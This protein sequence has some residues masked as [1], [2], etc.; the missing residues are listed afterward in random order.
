MKYLTT[1][2]AGMIVGIGISISI[3]YV[4]GVAMNGKVLENPCNILA[5]ELKDLNCIK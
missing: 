3:Q 4:S 5:K 1:F 2:I